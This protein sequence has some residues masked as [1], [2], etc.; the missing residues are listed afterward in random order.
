MDVEGK[1]S[2]WNNYAVELHPSV[3]YHVMIILALLNISDLL[4]LHNGIRQECNNFDSIF[5][6]II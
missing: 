4:D 2:E 3:F 5:F 1:K 6:F